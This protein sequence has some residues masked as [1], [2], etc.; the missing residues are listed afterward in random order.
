MWQL[1]APHVLAQGE[2]DTV[3]ATSPHVNVNTIKNF[4]VTLPTKEKQQAILSHLDKHVR[5]FDKLIED[6]ATAISLLRERSRTLI[7][8]AVTGKIDVRD[9]QPTELQS[10]SN[11]FSESSPEALSAFASK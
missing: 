4:A 2:A 6:A 3:G 9:W 8:A 10:S 5:A 1:N 11:S 7:S